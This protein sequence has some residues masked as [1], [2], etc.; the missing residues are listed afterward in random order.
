MRTQEY[1]F[2]YLMA[3]KSERFAIAGFRLPK[4]LL[5]AGG[6]PLFERTI[7]TFNL[8]SCTV[9]INSDQLQF[10]SM[11]EQI[12]HNNGVLLKLLVI[13]PH[14]QGPS[15]SLFLAANE[16]LT[17][18]P[19]LIAYCDVGFT[20]DSVQFN[21]SLK[22][23]DGLFLTFSGFQMH[24]I[25]N[26]RF[27]Y[28]TVSEIGEI[29]AVHEKFS[30]TLN[31]S[32]Q[33]SAGVY[34]FSSGTLMLKAITNQIEKTISIGGEFYISE[35]FEY[36][37]ENDLKVT[38][39]KLQ[40]FYSWGTPEDLSD[41]NYFSNMALNIH[42]NK[43]SQTGFSEDKALFL[44]AGKSSRLNKPGHSP[45]QKLILGNRELWEYSL[46]LVASRSHTIAILG[47][48][49]A[50]RVREFKSKGISVIITPQQTEN[51]LESALC[52]F[53]EILE[54]QGRLH[55]LATDNICSMPKPEEFPDAADLVV[56]TSKKYPLAYYKQKAFSWV[57]V[58]DS[59]HIEKLSVKFLPE[60]GPSWYPLTGNFSFKSSKIAYEL[61]AD[62][63]LNTAD[64]SEIH[65]ESI[66]N[67]ALTLN[68][69]VMIM[70][71]TEYMTIG[72]PEEYELARFWLN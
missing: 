28:V 11:I 33:G 70:D 42:L 7:E 48:S 1:E 31:P 4:A 35:A 59:N 9:I 62:T 12:C 66:I 15:Y 16:F 24:D 60:V 67:T 43:P 52:A 51:S 44:A 69:S 61:I 40:R 46:D 71:L 17:D 68:Y 54:N 64:D 22:K 57:M 13:T 50:G 47:P 32:M 41:Y 10:K 58:S 72:T 20:I 49:L 53:P 19:V 8:S 3:G 45:K 37:L 30:G 5:E 38:A 56:W 25:R 26:P 39:F 34:Y 65:F 6:I 21:I 2:V 27:G 14:T 55:I 29:T 36:L 18:R 63:L 23:S